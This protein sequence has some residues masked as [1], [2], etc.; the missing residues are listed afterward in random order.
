[1]LPRAPDFRIDG[2]RALVTGAGRGIGL[3][4]AAA[5]AQAGAEVTLAARSEPE[6][7]EACAQIRAEGGR[8]SHLVLDVT[9]AKAVEAALSAAGPFQVLVNNAG[10]N[11]PKLLVDVEDAD[12]DAVFDLN[13]KA[14]FYVTRS[15]ARGLLA[16]GLP[17]SIVNVSSQMGVV[18]SPRRSL[19]CASKHAMEGMTKAL[20]WE[21]GHANIR[22]NTVCPTFIETAMTAGMFADP[23]F[24]AWVVERIALGRL[25]RVEE[26]MGAIVFLASDASSLMTGSALMLDGGW[27]AA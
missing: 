7:R 10:L 24:R 11:R 21:L 6:L 23:A 18:G 14:A 1:M 25:G 27:S 19:Y 5:L 20:A 9:D 2:R 17:G 4:A 12:I 8:C 22:V 26:I 13:V 15:V 3:A 16:A